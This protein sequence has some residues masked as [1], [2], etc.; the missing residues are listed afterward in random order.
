MQFVRD[1]LFTDIH[2]HMEFFEFVQNLEKDDDV[3]MISLLERLV[4][5]TQP[6]TSVSPFSPSVASHLKAFSNR[7]SSSSTLSTVSKDLPSNEC[8]KD[9]F[10]IAMGYAALTSLQD[11]QYNVYEY[12]YLASVV[13]TKKTVLLKRAS[14]MAIFAFV[15]QVTFFWSLFYYNVV[16]MRRLVNPEQEYFI[17]VVVI[18]IGTSAIFAVILLGQFYE[19]T[20]FNA[21]MTLLRETHAAK[22]QGLERSMHNKYAAFYRPKLYLIFNTFVNKVLGV[23]IF[24]FNLYFVLTSPDPTSATYDA[25]LL[26]F[27]IEIDEIFM[28]NWSDNKVQGMLAEL[29]MDYCLANAMLDSPGN[30]I[31]SKQN[32]VIVERRS[33]PA[34]EVE[35]A[36]FYIEVFPGIWS[37]E[38]LNDMENDFGIS[39]GSGGI[40]NKCEL[41]QADNGRFSVVVYSTADDIECS[42]TTTCYNRTVYDIKGPRAGEL[43]EA[44]SQF[45]CL[46]NFHEIQV[47]N[48]PHSKDQLDG[49]P[50]I[51]E[52]N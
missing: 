36:K 15:I 30:D 43:Y 3:L 40:E 38:D 45:I 6:L 7:C 10:R 27:I 5:R 11:H 41:V 46:T 24:L 26:T 23:V 37:N 25:V 1:F 8:I 2:N 22:I 39:V 14:A 51:P 9:P 28:P 50:L 42:N 33:G 47:E 49:L 12:A 29:F 32:N 31:N 34:L 44:F 52:E 18:M 17:D 21:T 35:V 20:R 16:G 4:N 19:A 13:P 48:H